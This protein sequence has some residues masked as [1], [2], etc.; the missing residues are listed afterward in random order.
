LRIGEL[1]SLGKDSVS[2]W[3]EDYAPSMGAAIAFYTIFSLAPMLIIVIAVAG[4]VF[5]EE[6]AR[7]EL[8]SRIGDMAGE[9]AAGAVEGVLREASRPGRGLVAMVFGVAAIA[10]GATTVFAE[11]RSALNRIWQVPDPPS[12]GIWLTI[13]SRFIAFILVLA[14]AGLLLGL[15]A[16]SAVITALGDVWTDYLGGWDIVLRLVD[17][18]VSFAVLTTLFAL[19]Y[20]YVPRANIAWSDVWLGAAVTAVLFIIGRYLIGLYLG[21]AGIGSGFGAAGSLVV[22]LMW[23][24][25][26]AQI[27]LLGAEFTWVYAHRYGSRAVQVSS[28]TEEQTGPLTTGMKLIG[29]VATVGFVIGM[30]TR[31]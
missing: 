17:L 2:A 16:V 25:Y 24:Y 19:I 26:S 21:T 1:W 5:G 20:R 6:A 15:V 13:W 14:I 18:V 22:L 28:G 9:D 4:L 10:I 7:A 3:S 12:G 23:V 30:I 27:F 8:L 11:L 29:V 31:R